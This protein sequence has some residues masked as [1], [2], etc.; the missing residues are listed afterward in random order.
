MATED[1]EQH[2][3]FFFTTCVN[4]GFTVSRSKRLLQSVWL[5]Q[6]SIPS[7]TGALSLVVSTQGMELTVHPHP[8]SILIMCGAIFSLPHM[9]SWVAIFFPFSPSGFVARLP[10]KVPIVE[11]WPLSASISVDT[12][13]FTYYRIWQ[14]TGKTDKSIET[15]NKLQYKSA[16]KHTE[17]RNALSWLKESECRL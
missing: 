4:H 11:T 5:T 13:Y 3:L 6:S 9:P 12:W 14:Q 17:N 16:K 1:N 10:L 2:I 8:A 7:A 15:Y